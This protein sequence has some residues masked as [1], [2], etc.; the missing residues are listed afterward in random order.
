MYKK[1]KERKERQALE[2]LEY[3]PIFAQKKRIIKLLTL[4]SENR[5]LFESL[6]DIAVRFYT[7]G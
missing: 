2:P 6:R 3:D 5:G 4:Q 1:K 7:E